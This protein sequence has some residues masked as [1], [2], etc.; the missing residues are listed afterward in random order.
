M[1]YHILLQPNIVVS[2]V[3][4]LWVGQQSN[5]VPLQVGVK[6]FFSTSKHSEWLWGPPSVSPIPRVLGALSSGIKQLRCK[7]DHL[8]PSNAKVKG[9]IVPPFHMP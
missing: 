1:K 5:M 6:D 8:S 3:T 7:D 4:R 9:A 2:T